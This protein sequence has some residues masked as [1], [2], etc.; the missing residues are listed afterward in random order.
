[1]MFS[2]ESSGYHHRLRDNMSKLVSII[3]PT[4][5][6]RP[7]FLLE[8]CQSIAAQTYASWEGLII[9]TGDYDPSQMLSGLE[10]HA[11]FRL[12]SSTGTSVAAAR[13]TGL[14]HARGSYIAYLDDD[15]VWG[16][17]YLQMQITRLE[18]SA[19]DAVWCNHHLI[20]Q[21]W[22]DQK[23]AY[24]QHF[25][26]VPYNVDPFDRQTL[27]YEQYI[28]LSSFVHTR[29]NIPK[30]V[31]FQEI[32]VFDDWRFV[33][34]A[35][36]MFRFAHNPMS[37][38]SIRRRLD[39]TNRRTEPGNEVI[40]S[41]WRLFQE[42]SSEVT[43]PMVETYR[44][45]LLNQTVRLYEEQGQREVEQLILLQ[46][47]GVDLAYGYLVYLM[48]QQMLNRPVCEMGSSIALELGHLELAQD[49]AWLA[50][51]YNPLQEDVNPSY[52]LVHFTRKNER[53]I[54]SR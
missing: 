49:L 22:D 2:C 51:W 4:D 23:K 37:L 33:I 10:Q 44:S 7:E 18:E 48:D 13:N 36:R 40:R 19:S 3:I 28:H 41:L 21:A 26:A 6:R 42:T 25:M 34:D 39:G 53:W 43:G 31:Q 11:R 50:K 27:L 45:I 8:A 5:G 24:Y 15:D 29:D 17:S 38:V 32:P 46:T 54:V 9:V 52:Q 30:I 20:T 35:S 16:E 12:I 47:R 1:M 14:Q